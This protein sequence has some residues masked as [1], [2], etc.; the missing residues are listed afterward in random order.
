MAAIEREDATD[1]FDP[2]EIIVEAS[3]AGPRLEKDTPIT[4]DW[5]VKLMEF[6]KGEKRVH[7]KY[8]CLF[9]IGDG[10]LLQGTTFLY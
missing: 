3:Y 8:V 5:C 6:L 2:S 4:Y 7:K 10:S 9:D 1:S